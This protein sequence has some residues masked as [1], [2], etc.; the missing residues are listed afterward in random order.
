MEVELE[1]MGELVVDQNLMLKKSSTNVS[2]KTDGNTR[3]MNGFNRFNLRGPLNQKKVEAV[4]TEGQGKKSDIGP[5]STGMQR[6]M[7][8][9]SAPATKADKRPIPAMFRRRK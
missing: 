6:F 1:E 4:Q 2:N 9:D 7:K 8:G 3:K 5:V